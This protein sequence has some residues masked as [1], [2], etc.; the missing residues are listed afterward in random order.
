M[1]FDNP[2]WQM[3]GCFLFAITV[4][5]LV[6]KLAARC[7][8]ETSGAEC[9]LAF[10][11]LPGP[12]SVQ[13][14]QPIVSHARVVLRFLCLC[15][16]ATLS[17]FIYWQLVYALNIQGI[18][19]S[20]L[21]AP[22]LLLLTEMLVALAAVLWLPSGQLLAPLHNRPWRARSVA[23][24]W[25]QRWN[26]YYS[27]WTRFT[28]FQPLRRRPV[29]ALLLAFAFSALLHEAV[30]NVPLYFVTGRA[31]FGTM[32]I[33]FLAQPIG[34]LL[35]R[36]FKSKPAVGVACFWVFVVL[37]APLIINEGLLRTMHLW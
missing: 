30:I 36:R 8:P 14:L 22:I 17:Y 24:F 35:E 13:R 5:V 2:D 25:G 33:Y 31:L 34:V 11:I 32:M 18:F 7:V 20:Y 27:D 16:A 28:I 23:D 4:M 3:T 37:P 6:M 19:R 1:L 12:P 10:W 29:L 26:T 15:G 21:A 9:G